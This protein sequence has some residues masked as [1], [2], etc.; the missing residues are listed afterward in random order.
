LNSSP[1]FLKHLPLITFYKHIIYDYDYIVNNFSKNKKI[2]RKIYINM[3]YLIKLIY[4]N[5][6]IEESRHIPA[7]SKSRLINNKV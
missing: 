1:L 2:Y 3:L 5:E 4:Y 6:N 7:K